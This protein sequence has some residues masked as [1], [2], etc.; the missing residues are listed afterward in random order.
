MARDV[1]W[2]KG[3]FC[4]GKAHGTG[5]VKF[6]EPLIPRRASLAIRP[7]AIPLPSMIRDA[8]NGPE[9]IATGL[10]VDRC[11]SSPPSLAWSES[12]EEEDEEEAGRGVL[13]GGGA[14]EIPPLA[15]SG[16]TDEEEDEEE[17]TS[18][19][20]EEEDEEND[21][22]G[23]RANGA[24]RHGL[25]RGVRRR[26]ISSSALPTSGEEKTAVSIGSG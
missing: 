23:E 24:G 6:K 13:V 12:K 2:Y 26:A 10:S 17:D 8:G 18:D 14:V 5:V 3:D 16:T 4:R 22:A 9:H 21:V 1:L 15:L 25:G 20:D 19:S 7:R 11:P